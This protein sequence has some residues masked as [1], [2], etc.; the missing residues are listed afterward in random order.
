MNTRTHIRL[1]IQGL[2]ALAVLA[3]IVF[4][5]RAEW[6]PGGFLGVDVF[7]VVSGFVVS[8]V[9]LQ[10]GDSFSW[11]GFYANR[12]R[13]I[14]P[15][16][17]AMLLVVALLAAV[18]LV[19]EDFKLFEASLRRALL[20][21]S[22]QHFAKAGDYFAPAAHEWPLLHTWSLAVEMQFYLL[23][24]LVLRWAPQRWR[25]TV[26]GLLCI[27]GFAIAQWR[28][29]RGSG[30]LQSL[31]YAM[32][33]RAPEFL[34]GA[35]LATVQ[36]SRS[37]TPAAW[38]RPA[39]LLGMALM[40]SAFVFLDG[41]RFSPLAAIWPCAGALLLMAAQDQSTTGRWLSH[42]WLVVIGALSYS[43]YLWHWPLLA[44]ARYVWQ[45]SALPWP[46]LGAMALLFSL[47]AWLSWRFIERP[48]QKPQAGFRRSGRVAAV[49]A[50]M[51]A[52]LVATRPLNAGVA[53]TPEK[54]ALRYAPPDS[55]CH[56]QVTGLCQRGAIDGAT[57]VLL[58]GDSH[59]AQLN[60]FMDAFGQAHGVRAT[61]LSASSC[62]PLPGFEDKRLAHWAIGP[63]Q[64]MQ[65]AVEERLAE[66]RT[67][68]LAGKWSQQMANP[69]FLP[70]LTRFLQDT[71]QHSQRVIVLA[72]L[73]M[74]HRNPV[75]A[76]RM[77]SLGIHTANSVTP[78]A[79]DAN[80]VIEAVVRGFPHA[81]FADFSSSALF[82]A[83]PF[84]DHELI[85]MDKHHLNEI[86][87]LRYAQAAAHPLAQL[88]SPSGRPVSP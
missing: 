78:E 39:G 63:C 57:N 35:W 50:M 41:A 73:P 72:Q 64:D 44:L 25:S 32:T 77:D 71:V 54:A 19:P 86:G 21:T 47:L 75:R 13:R 36:A 82:A 62:V 70:T 85:Y 59:A 5:M 23:L 3:V 20:F 43:L 6:L 48:W 14:V 58:F 22:N 53:P 7:F 74:M 33:A 42:R 49:A 16:Y 11:L 80:A 24:P 2:R 38:Q 60:L 67:V 29:T 31:Y 40:L 84:F 12:V 61:V 8:R 30:D 55:I 83:P 88:L 68:I 17:A 1:D 26:L 65:K 34:M 15:A 28:L 69:A 52:S 45:D 9:I 87:S 56:G 18:L 10:R 46:L 81:T 27:A 51:V 66:Q 79:R 76:L 4:H 37:A